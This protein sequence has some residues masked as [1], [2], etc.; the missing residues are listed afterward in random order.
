MPRDGHRPV[1]DTC[2]Q[3]P[4]AGTERR[5]EPVDA[6]PS[7]R[8]HH[9]GTCA[10]TPRPAAAR[11]DPV[12]DAVRDRRPRQRDP[13]PQRRGPRFRRPPRTH[14]LQRRRHQM[15]L[16]GLRHS[17][18]VFLFP[19][20]ETY[21]RAPVGPGSAT[22]APCSPR[23]P[24]GTGPAPT[25]RHSAA[26]FLGELGIPL[27]LIMAKTRHKNP[28]TAMRYKPRPWPNHRT[29]PTSAPP[30]LTTAQ[31]SSKIIANANGCTDPPRTPSSRGGSRRRNLPVTS[32]TRHMMRD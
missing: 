28:G 29:T 16:L 3:A 17:T 1:R 21:A 13:G 15:D 8:P 32:F 25:T 20:P 19:T 27:Q 31:L 26:T 24:D 23:T 10:V 14:P 18:P 12:A 5:R 22:T 11:K 6:T 2:D 4:P 7:H 30:R 9:P